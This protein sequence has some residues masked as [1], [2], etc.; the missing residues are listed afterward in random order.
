MHTSSVIKRGLLLLGSFAIAYNF[1]VSLHELS[2]LLAAFLT[3]GTCDGIY[4]NPFSW[5][6]ANGTSPNPLL[7]T[8]AGPFWSNFFGL[9][10]FCMAWRWYRSVLMPFLLIGPVMLFFN[11]GYLLI[12]TLMQSGGDGCSMINQGVSPMFVIIAAMVLLLAGLGLSVLFVRR[13]RLLLANFKGR[14]IT[15]SLGIVP[16]L[17]TVAAWNF[18]YNRP[19]IMLWLTYA[20]LGTVSILLAAMPSYRRVIQSDQPHPLRWRGV[21]TVNL[22]A[23]GLVAFFLVTGPLSGGGTP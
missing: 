22:S 2:H 15:L 10:P 16:Y 13:T 14:L 8:T 6:Y 11:G 4:I 23:I 17:A 18:F 7:F 9:I 21:I 19:E 1:S 12:D 20:V 5:S 3:G